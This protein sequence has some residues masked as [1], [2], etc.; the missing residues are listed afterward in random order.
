[1]TSKEALR[2]FYRTPQAPSWR[3]ELAIYGQ[4]IANSMAK[5]RADSDATNIGGMGAVELGL[6]AGHSGRSGMDPNEL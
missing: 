1:M 6:L 2:K 5:K 4:E 3:L